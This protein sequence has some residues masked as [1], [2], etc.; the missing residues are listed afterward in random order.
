MNVPAQFPMK[1]LSQSSRILIEC[2]TKKPSIF[3]YDL[4]VL[5]NSYIDI[6]VAR[7]H[8]LA[9]IIYPDEF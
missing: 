5:N 4:Q 6:L 1:P 3:D 7:M 9:N 8:G 2:A